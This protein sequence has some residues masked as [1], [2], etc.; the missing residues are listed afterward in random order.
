MRSG[1]R[2]MVGVVGAVV[3]LVLASRPVAPAMAVDLSGDPVVGAVGDMA[4]DPSDPNFNGGSGTATHCAEARVSALMASETDIDGVLGLGDYQY[5]CN[6]P[7]D[8]AV[9]YTPTWGVMNP[10]MTPVAGNHE[11]QAG[12]DPFG[13]ACPS[14]NKTAQQFFNYFATS[15]SLWAGGGSHS[16]SAGHFSFDIGGWH[17]IALNANCTKTGVGGC[18]STSPQTTWLANDLAATTQPCIL[19]YWHQPRWTG[20]S[21]NSSTTSAWWTLLYQAQADLVLNGHIHNYQR[22]AQLNPSGQA[23]P[24]GVREVIVGTGGESVSSFPLNPSPKPTAR[25]RL[26]GYLRLDLHPD[27]YDGSFIAADGTTKDSFSASCH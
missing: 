20:I 4:C 9:S 15:G 25:F 5:A 14:T 19:A 2:R 11:Y 21:K 24:N 23:D 18:G 8:F 10:W 16:A 7:N 17:I 22:F 12:T 27:S 6:D 13:T 1:T 3:L 26:F